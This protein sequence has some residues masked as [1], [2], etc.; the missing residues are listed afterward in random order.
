MKKRIC[1]L[2][3]LLLTVA[4]CTTQT[5]PPANT[6]K[7]ADTTETAAAESSLW[8]ITRPDIM[9]FTGPGY[10][11]TDTGTLLQPGTYAVNEETVDDEG[12]TWGKLTSGAGWIDLTKATAEAPH[13]PLTLARTDAVT[14]RGTDCHLHIVDETDYTQWLYLKAYETLTDVCLSFMDFTEEGFRPGKTMYS[15]DMWTADKPLILGVVFY[16]DFSTFALTFTDAAGAE[17]TYMIY[18]SSRNGSVVLQEYVL[19]E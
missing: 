19:Q 9:T 17:H 14:A 7:I 11:Y 12:F 15:L 13:I 18:E 5:P 16:G 1:L 10:D 3:V 6:T 8:K 4:G 2:L